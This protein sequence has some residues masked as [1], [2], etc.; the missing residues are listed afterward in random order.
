[1]IF[2]SKLIHT[3]YSSYEGSDNLKRR[4]GLAMNLLVF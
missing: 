4:N 3:R 2:Y 1:M